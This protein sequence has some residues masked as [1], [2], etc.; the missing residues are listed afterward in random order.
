MNYAAVFTFLSHI[1]FTPMERR[2]FGT[3]ANSQDWALNCRDA[4]FGWVCLWGRQ[5]GTSWE[6]DF[7][8]SIKLDF[9]E[10][11]LR[12]GAGIGWGAGTGAGI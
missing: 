4:G 5:E 7:G 3:L 1:L 6:L 11:S 2:L 9:G 12:D 8:T 10:L